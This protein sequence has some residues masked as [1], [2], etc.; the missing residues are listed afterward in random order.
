MLDCNIAV[1]CMLSEKCS[2]SQAESGVLEVPGCLNLFRSIL[3]L[4]G[5]PACG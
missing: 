4:Q 5:M 3:S 2:Q 1:D